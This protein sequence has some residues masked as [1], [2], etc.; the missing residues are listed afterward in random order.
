MFVSTMHNVSTDS[1]AEPSVSFQAMTLVAF[2][3][4]YL[5]QMVLAALPN[6]GIAFQY[7]NLV[8]LKEAKGLLTQIEGIGQQTPPA[9]SIDEHY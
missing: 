9:T 6:V 2:T 4:Y 7:F 1:F 3:L 8:E 5:A